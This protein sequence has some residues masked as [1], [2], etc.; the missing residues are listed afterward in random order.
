MTFSYGYW[1]VIII[2]WLGTLIICLYNVICDVICNVD[3]HICG[4]YQIL[5]SKE[6]YSNKGYQWMSRGR[7]CDWQTTSIMIIKNRDHSLM[8][9]V[10]DGNQIWSTC[11]LFAICMCFRYE[12]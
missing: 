1:L 12:W 10:K 9:I 7:N 4:R 2:L 8:I 6:L 5:L 11:Y 3:I